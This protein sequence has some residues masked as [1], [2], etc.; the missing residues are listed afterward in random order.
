L[1]EIL[2]AAPKAG[3]DQPVKIQ[4]EIR[5]H[6][7]KAGKPA[8]VEESFLLLQDAYELI[9]QLG[10]IPCYPV[11]ADGQD[12][13]SAYESPVEKLIE[14]LAAAGIW[15]TEFIP[16]RNSVETV[17]RYVPAL[18]RAGFAVTAG[19]EHNTL[20]LIGIEPMCFK[21]KAVPEEIMAIFRE[22]ACVVAG[23]QQLNLSGKVGFTDDRGRLNPAYGNQE[24]RIRQL[25]TIGAAVVA[26]V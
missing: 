15:M 12:P 4:D 10:G 23:H 14:N 24:Q 9:V 22:G 17:E 7:M 5:S 6:L 26:R 3:E 2:G 18:R 25:A 13:I 8:F 19:T 16:V 21:G 1:A 20:D 11:L